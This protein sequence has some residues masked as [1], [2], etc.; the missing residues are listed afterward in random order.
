[1]LMSFLGSVLAIETEKAWSGRENAPKIQGPLVP[2][3]VS[4]GVA[5]QDEKLGEKTQTGSGW[6]GSVP[7]G[8]RMATM[9][10]YCIAFL[11]R[12]VG[13]TVPTVGIRSTYIHNLVI[14]SLYVQN[15]ARRKAL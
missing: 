9:G 5:K 1:M 4:F 11:P 14:Q 12:Y 3:L 13:P 2:S 15:N 7:G 6:P 10:P 8:T